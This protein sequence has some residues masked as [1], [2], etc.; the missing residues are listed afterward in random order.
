[1]SNIQKSTIKEIAEEIAIDNTCYIQRLTKKVITID[2]SLEDPKLI[3]AQEQTLAELERKI[4]N[5]IK[6][7]K[8]STQDKRVIMEYFLE[9]LPD[10]SVRKELSNALNRKNPVR[11]FNK[12][13]ESDIDLNQHWRNFK[14]EEYQRWVSN[15]I[16]DAY[17]YK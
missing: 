12:A 13:V 11:N 7:E 16:A 9:E 6:I 14:A 10:R 4:E 3:A 17:L 15:F 2:H 1:M 8:L 5:Y